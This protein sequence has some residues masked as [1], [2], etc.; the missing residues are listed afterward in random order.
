MPLAAQTV[1]ETIRARIGATAFTDHPHPF[2]EGELP[3]WRVEVTEEEH[4][5]ATLNGGTVLHRT[6]IRLKGVARAVDG[7]D[8]AL[9]AMASTALPLVLASPVPYGIEPAGEITRE[10]ASEGEAAVGLI[11]IPLRATYFTATNDPNTIL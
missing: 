7:L 9:N 8:A 2:A 11:D 6:E 4:E 5:L 10:F 1:A 3:A